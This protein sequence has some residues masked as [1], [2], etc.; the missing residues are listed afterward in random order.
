MAGFAAT[1]RRRLLKPADPARAV[2]AHAVSNRSEQLGRS[3]PPPRPGARSAAR[4]AGTVAGCA[5]LR[6][7][8]VEVAPALALVQRR[9]RGDLRPSRPAPENSRERDGAC[10]PGWDAQACRSLHRPVSSRA[11]AGGGWHGVGVVGRTHPDGL[12]PR[13]VALKLPH[14]AW[15]GTGFAERMARERSILAALHPSGHRAPV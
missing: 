14:H 12:V 7:P 3:Q 9:R 11:R 10:H 4:G 13:P 1:A 2:A 5:R 15:R 6:R 8:A